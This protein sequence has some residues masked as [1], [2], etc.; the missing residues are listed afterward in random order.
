MESCN[1][2]KQK[3]PGEDVAGWRFGPLHI[4][5]KTSGD[6]LWLTSTYSDEPLAAMPE[7]PEWRR[8]TLR[9]LPGEIHFK[10]AFP[11]LPVVV[12]P[13]HPFRVVKK[14]HTKIYVRVPL[15]VQI[16]IDNTPITE[17][18]SV[19]LS[20][21]WFGNFVDGE[22]CYWIASAARKQ[23]LFETVRQYLAVCPI[24][25]H[26]RSDEELLVEKICHR[27]GRL[28]LYR[29]GDNFWGNETKVIFR[30]TG[31]ISEI[32]FNSKPPAEAPKTKPVAPPRFE[33]RRSLTAKTFE[34]LVDLAKLE[35][36]HR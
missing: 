27:V 1:W 35:F 20:K 14:V 30:G 12:K 8:W 4:W 17:F 19:V 7:N 33:P 15:W 25:I 26:N 22:L 10:P 9:K 3:M 5:G 21:T 36:L 11:D 13:E 29:D 2:G 18:P 16:E 6:E 24:A 23:P 32:E 34:S 28:T 31:E